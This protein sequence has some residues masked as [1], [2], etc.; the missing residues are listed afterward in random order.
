V[1]DSYAGNVETCMRRHCEQDSSTGNV[2]CFVPNGP[3]AVKL[4]E[5]WAECR[6]RGHKMFV[7]ARHV[8]P[9]P[10]GSSL[11]PVSHADLAK[12]CARAKGSSKDDEAPV[13]PPAKRIKKGRPPCKYGAGCYQKN[14]LHRAKFSHPGDPEF[15][16]D[17]PEIASS[18]ALAGPMDVA[19][20]PATDVT[21]DDAD[22]DAV[23]A[24]SSTDADTAAAA[25][26]EPGPEAAPGAPGA[27]AAAAAPAAPED[28]PLA[29]PAVP[30]PV[31]PIPPALPEVP[32]PSTDAAAPAEV[33]PAIP[34][35][36]KE[37]RDCDC[38]F[39]NVPTAD[40][41][42]CPS[43]AHFFCAACLANFLDAFKTADYADQKKAKGRALCPM[44]DSDTPFGDGVLAAIVPQE[45]FDNYLQIR[46]KVAEQSIQ[47]QFEKENTAKIEELKEKLAK[48]T[49]SGEQLE[50]DKH[51]LKI[52]DD[53][54]TLKCPRCGMAFLDYD[55]CS[56]IT[57]SACKCGF[58]SFCLEDCGKDAH[59]HFYKNGSKCPNEGGALFVAHNIWQGYQNAR[60][61]RLLCEYLAGLADD[62]RKKVADL[63]APDAKDLGIEMPKDLSP[64]GLMPEAH[65]ILRLK[66][67]IPRRLRR[68][69]V[70]LQKGLPATVELKIPDSSAVR[71]SSPHMG[72]IIALKVTCTTYAKG[73]VAAHL[74]ADHQVKIEDEWVECK[75]AK[76]GKLAKGV[77]KAKHVVG[78][79]AIGKDVSLKEANGCG[80]V[81]VRKTPSQEEGKNA[82][83]YWDDG[84]KV[85][86]LNHWIE[87]T[88]E[89]PGPSKRGIVQATCVPDNDIT[90]RGPDEDCKALLE[91]FE[92]KLGFKVETFPLGGAK[93]KAA[94]KAK[95]KPKA[96]GK[97]KAKA[98]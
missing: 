41:T 51:R 74:P 95:A 30:P 49:G 19:G 37:S 48:A 47:E 55:N 32:A 28:P 14:P 13:E 29:P 33:A 22:V 63:V 57:C 12:P 42:C 72:P 85:K 71:L 45:I 77:I 16:A 94:G 46:I 65:G 83:G 92:E 98:A 7:K 79:L 18:S 24:T 87:C 17:V 86:V 11:D 53:I 64:A 35:E 38:C 61:E 4:V 66:L 89:G 31:P 90:L 26:A 91:R 80:S 25:A 9:A 75:G 44:K 97:A 93:P 50:L 1:R 34:A 88:W 76:G 54:F 59:Q 84:T 43:K 67:S 73:S 21:M 96:K 68:L 27:P 10:A 23:P 60:K 5:R 3:K 58:C 62:L 81:L 39:D 8:E 40:G 82:L 20:K 15:G 56:A 6:W 69:I 78:P 70:P 52:I 36:A 2:V